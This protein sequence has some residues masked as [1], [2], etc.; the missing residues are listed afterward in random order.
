MEII[1]HVFKYIIAYI[2]VP[3]AIMFLIIGDL[4]ATCIL[5]FLVFWSVSC[6]RKTAKKELDKT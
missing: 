3:F 1:K 5:I 2:S 4:Y 6:E